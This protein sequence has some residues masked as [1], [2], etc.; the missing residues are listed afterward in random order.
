MLAAVLPWPA[1]HS[2]PAS[3]TSA[4]TPLSGQSH[5]VAPHFLLLP[6]SPAFSTCVRAH[7]EPWW[8]ILLWALF[9]WLGRVVAL[10]VFL[11]SQQTGGGGGTQTGFVAPL[12]VRS[13]AHEESAEGSYELPSTRLK[14]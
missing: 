6:M 5:C 12:P 10:H 8:L 9:S 3:V 7:G 2:P 4:R 11:K 13:V 1:A 14:S